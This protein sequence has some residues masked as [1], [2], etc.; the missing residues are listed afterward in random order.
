MKYKNKIGNEY[1]PASIWTS[2]KLSQMCALCDRYLC[3]NI[4][5]NAIEWFNLVN[6]N[7][8]HI[9]YDMGLIKCYLGRATDVYQFV[10]TSVW[11]QCKR[12]SLIWISAPVWITGS[13]NSLLERTLLQLSF[14]SCPSW[15]GHYWWSIGWNTFGVIPL[16]LVILGI[17]FGQV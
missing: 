15:V 5:I 11:R 14:T 13:A 4:S 16:G 1:F 7:L 17:A 3:L 8:P 9:T 6:L 10:S 12:L 2:W